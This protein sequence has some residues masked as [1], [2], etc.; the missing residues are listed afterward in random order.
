MNI[1]GE[2]PRLISVTILMYIVHDAA[3]SFLY[4]HLLFLLYF[5]YFLIL[6]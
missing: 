3:A 2:W 4:H 6:K 1:G 5:I